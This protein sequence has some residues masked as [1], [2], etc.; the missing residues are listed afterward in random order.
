MKKIF[1]TII[2]A[3]TLAGCSLG[4]DMDNTPTKQVE[5]YLNNYQTLNTNVLS[6]LDSI[7][8]NEI[9]FN[10][11]QKNDY[12]DIL[13]KHYQD[14]NYTIKEE[15]VNGDKATV[16]V[17]IEVNDYTKALKQA[18]SDRTAKASDFYDNSNN[19]D[20]SKFNDYRLKLLK[21][22]KEKVKYTLYFSLTKNQNEWVLDSL[23]DTE[24]E[25]L[26]GI[27]EY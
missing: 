8:D 13:K 18:E 5:K 23:T 11:T 22:N 16:E 9:T 25:K 4:A 19:F 1:L 14:L 3:C 17:E 10:E 27:Y 21:D 15:T 24:Q 6:E 7:V 12:R 2:M 26:L 20:E